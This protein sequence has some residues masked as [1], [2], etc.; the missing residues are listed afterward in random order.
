VD[1]DLHGQTPLQLELALG[2]YEIRLN[3]ARHFEWE[4]QLNLA[5]VGETPLFARLVPIEE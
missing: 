3:L 2:K 1:G 5:Q 4:A